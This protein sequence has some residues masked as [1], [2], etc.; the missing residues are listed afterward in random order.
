MHH[1]IA[2]EFFSSSS[3]SRSSQGLYLNAGQHKHRINAYTHQISMP[4]VGFEL[5]IPAFERV[6]TVHALDS[7]T[8]V[9]GW[10]SIG[11]S[12]LTSISDSELCQQEL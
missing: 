10:N 12:I 4:C 1:I 9:R 5:T 2:R 6:K 11:N 3:C 7:S 8:T